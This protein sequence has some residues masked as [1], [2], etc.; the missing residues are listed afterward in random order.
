MAGTSGSSTSSLCKKC[1]ENVVSGLKCLICESFF[2]PS[3]G[4][5][6]HVKTVSDNFIICCGKNE[7]CV[8]VDSAFFDAIEELSDTSIK[9]DINIF[10]YIVKQK[11]AIITQLYDEIKLLDE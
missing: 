7:E 11:D 6:K 5:L 9:I 8:D 1:K 2:H 3:C 4:R 10:H